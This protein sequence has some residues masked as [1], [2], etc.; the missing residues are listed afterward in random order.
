M[1]LSGLGLQSEMTI[2]CNLLLFRRYVSAV[3]AEPRETVTT[4]DVST[5]TLA[6]SPSQQRPESRRYVTLIFSL[7]SQFLLKPW[8][9][10]LVSLSSVLACLLACQMC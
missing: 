1:I 2:I 9:A 5:P 7:I 4:D 10:L 3:S 6:F 8:P